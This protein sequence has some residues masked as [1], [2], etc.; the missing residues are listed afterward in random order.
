VRRH[1]LA[2]PPLQGTRRPADGYAGSSADVVARWVAPLQHPS[3]AGEV[4]R[5]TT[6]TYA[7]SPARRP[8]WPAR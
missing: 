3:R 6:P 7:R 2:V 4:A 1:R 5:Y 8:Q